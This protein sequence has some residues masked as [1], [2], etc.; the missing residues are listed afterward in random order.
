MKLLY[1]CD[2]DYGDIK[3]INL[4]LIKNF[5][6]RRVPKGTRVDLH[7]CIE[8][9]LYLDNTLVHYFSLDDTYKIYKQLLADDDEIRKIF[10]T[11]CKYF[12]RDEEGIINW[13]G[14][15]NFESYVKKSC[16]SRDEFFREYNFHGV[17]D[18]IRILECNKRFEDSKL[19]TYYLVAIRIF[20]Y[21]ITSLKMNIL[22]E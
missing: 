13:A 6:C 3:A 5:E 2:V 9:G 22:S 15:K 4:E 18:Y 16:L 21:Y 8:Y 14:I 19:I 11:Y 12:I 17:R 7:D 10:H 1:C 20:S